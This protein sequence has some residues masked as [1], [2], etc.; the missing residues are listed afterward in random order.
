[1]SLVLSKGSY[2]NEAKG[3]VGRLCKGEPGEGEVLHCYVSSL[4]VTVTNTQIDLALRGGRVNDLLSAIPS[5]SSA[6]L[7]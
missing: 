5:L 3:P 4:N 7:H 2:L 1:M 6:V